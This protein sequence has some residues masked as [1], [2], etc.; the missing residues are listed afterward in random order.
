M[1]N[2]KIKKILTGAG[3]IAAVSG[4]SGGMAVSLSSENVEQ[5]VVEYTYDWTSPENGDLHTPQDRFTTQ[6]R[7]WLGDNKVDSG[8]TLWDTSSAKKEAKMYVEDQ[9]LP[10]SG[11]DKDHVSNFTNRFGNTTDGISMKETSDIQLS[12]S[13][14]WNLAGSGNVNSQEMSLHGMF[15]DI[16]EL[17]DV[18]IST[19]NIYIN[20]V[21]YEKDV[22]TY[23]SSQLFWAEY[24][25]ETIITIQNFTYTIV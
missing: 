16:L 3:A 22:H 13:W 20:S 23:F 4:V 10:G 12:L 6:S 11:G 25:I 24:S 18:D 15:V 2:N 7:V 1:K 17:R 19:Q 9:I 21:T 5:N 8:V 14:D